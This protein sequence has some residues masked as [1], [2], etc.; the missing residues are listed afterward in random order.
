MSPPDHKKFRLGVSRAT[1]HR[2]FTDPKTGIWVRRISRKIRIPIDLYPCQVEEKLIVK[3]VKGET[4]MKYETK[5]TANDGTV[6]KLLGKFPSYPPSNEEEEPNK[7]P[8]Y[9]LLSYTVSDS[10][11]DLESKLV[12]ANGGNGGNGGNGMSWT[13]F[14][15]LL[16]EEFCPSNE[17]EKLETKF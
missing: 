14:K 12:N 17:M 11:S 10:D 4:I 7:G 2:S 1:G 6:T 3:E 5:I 8:N 16:V 15:V 13:D 9:Q